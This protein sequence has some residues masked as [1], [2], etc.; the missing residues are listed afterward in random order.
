MRLTALDEPAARPV[1]MTPAQTRYEQ[2]R[3]DPANWRLGLIYVCGDD[4]RVVVRQRH[5]LGW[6][7]NFGNRFVVPAIGIAILLFV[8]PPLTAWSLGVR[9][10]MALAI[11]AAA[12]LVVL[13]VLARRLA[14]PPD[15]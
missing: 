10:L 9:S 15:D 3:L 11:I 12:A 13:V 2:L 8:V 14:V 4:P 5:G 6:T 7:W 1:A